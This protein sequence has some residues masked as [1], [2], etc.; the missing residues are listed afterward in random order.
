[1]NGTSSGAYRQLL[2]PLVLTVCVM[3]ATVEIAGA[4]MAPHVSGHSEGAGA[5][6]NA[7]SGYDR[8][9][10]SAAVLTVTNPADS[11]TGTLRQALVDAAS[12][13]TIVFDPEVF[14]PSNPVTITV[15]TDLPTV[16]HGYLTIDAT[17]AGVILDGAGVAP[18]SG[19]GDGLNITSDWNAVKGLQILNF[20][21]DGVQI[22]GGACCNAV[23]QNVISGNAYHGVSIAGTG[24]ISNTVA[25]NLL[26]TDPSGFLALGNRTAGVA[27]GQGAQ[28]NLVGGEDA[29]ERNVISGNGDVGIVIDA[30]D[31]N[32]VSGNFVGVTSDGAA[33]LPN[34][35]SGV[36]ISGGAS[37]NV[38]GGNSPAHRNILSGNVSDG[39]LILGD[40]TTYNTVSGNYIGTDSTGGSALPNA[41]GVR[42]AGAQYII[43]GGTTAGERNVVSGNTGSGITVMR[44]GSSVSMSNTIV[45]NYVGTDATGTRAVGNGLPGVSLTDG[46]TWNAIGGSAPGQ[47]NIVSGNGLAGIVL[48]FYANRNTV[49]GNY[50]G[51]DLTGTSRLPNQGYGIQVG[52]G[53]NDNVI[54][55]NNGSL[56]GACSGA[57]NLVSGNASVG[58][59][60]E[61]DFTAYNVIS[62]NYVGTD[63]SGM[64]AIPNRDSGVYIFDDAHHNTIGGVAA[65]ERNV[66]S[67]NDR[68]GISIGGYGSDYNTII[69]NFIGPDAANSAAIGNKSSGVELWGGVQYNVI[70]GPSGEAN[71]IRGNA[72]TGVSV[73]G[74]NSLFNTIRQN[75]IYQNTKTGIETTSGG[76]A[77]L[78]APLI[79]GVDLGAGTAGGTACAGCTVDVFSDGDNQGQVYEGTTTADGAGSWYLDKGSPLVGPHVTATATDA[80]GNTS[81]F[82]SVSFLRINR[83]HDWVGGEFSEPN[84]PVI[85]TVV[86]SEGAVKGVIDAMTDRWGHLGTAVD[87]GAGHTVDIATGDVVFVQPEAGPP[88]S[89]EIPAMSA[90]VSSGSDTVSGHVPGGLEGQPIAAQIWELPGGIL[91]E[92]TGSLQADGSYQVQFGRFVLGEG[93]PVVVWYGDAQ[94]NWVGIERHWLRLEMHIGG[95]DVWGGTAP[96]ES[97]LVQVS[98]TVKKGEGLVTADDEGRYYATISGGQN[99][100]SIEIGD[101][102]VASAGTRTSTMK[103]PVLSGTMDVAADR[104]CGQA[105]ASS[106]VLVRVTGLYEVWAD[107]DSSGI[108]CVDLLFDLRFEHM[109]QIEYFDSEGHRVV[110]DLK[111]P[112]LDTAVLFLPLVVRNAVP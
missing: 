41:A 57:C 67:G 5:W 43:V 42:I 8:R 24:T 81:E 106:K 25:G 7:P 65:A 102:I 63:V 26:G 45:G 2:M 93:H 76:N 27:I 73:D 75:A 21:G 44:L 80:A 61:D 51:T 38:V 112:V 68:M 85:V 72:Q 48:G 97:V 20:P 95:S 79:T 78:P 10:A 110:T 91:R 18:G 90:S 33:A 11:G 47:R 74:H 4:T 15:T 9:I 98:D 23:E 39:V 66:I 12:G 92:A 62:G 50:V 70:G 36:M 30:S 71:I 60:V 84:M 22:H 46:A 107:A 32:V 14:S 53:A 94:G 89:T 101:R 59:A 40:T 3:V 83:S 108:Y 104:I 58:I 1:M 29:V 111:R 96:G 105:P 87:D 6:A 52:G 54:G 55:G 109:G 103:V 17:Q 86:D 82:A 77:E 35:G 56:G 99:P 13:N 28:G 37:H 49:A 64:S 16:D 31:S 69:G 19:H 34:E 88:L 100:V